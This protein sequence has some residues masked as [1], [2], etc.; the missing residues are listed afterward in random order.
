MG[1]AAEDRAKAADLPE[2]DVIRVLLEQHSRI[3]ELFS[4]VLSMDGE[5]KKHAFDDLRALLAVHETAEEMVLRPVTKETAGQAVVDARNQEEAEANKVLAELEKLDVDSPDFDEKLKTFEKAVDDHAE[6][7]EH[8]EFPTVLESCDEDRRKKM[9]THLRA[10]E[11]IAPTHPHPSTAG[12]T[13]AQY[14]VG[15]IAS[16]IDRTRDAITAAMR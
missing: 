4:E 15:P 2:G 13:A 3:R 7:E 12:S 1:D 14:A 8:E 6:A 5:H 10:A 16:L 9:G 11:G